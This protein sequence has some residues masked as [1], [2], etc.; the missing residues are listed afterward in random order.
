[1]VT[2]RNCYTAILAL[3]FLAGSLAAQPHSC[4]QQTV[5]GT[6]ALAFDGMVITSQAPV[7]VAGL[8]IVMIDPSGIVNAPGYMA[9]GSAPQWYPQGPGAMIVNT[10]CTGEVAWKD[11]QGQTIGIGELIV[12]DGGDEIDSIMIYSA[13]GFPVITGRWKRISRVP[14]IDHPGMCSPHSVF[15]TY[16][17]REK[18]VHVIPGAGPV[19]GEMLARIAI[20]HSG[21]VAMSGMVMIAANSTPMPITIANGK[22]VEGALAC[23]GMGTGDLEVGGTKIG[24]VEDWFVVLDGGNELWGISV[25]DPIGNPVALWTVKRASHQPADQE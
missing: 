21:T 3:L 25:A 14:D 9:V 20:D 16:V 12:R 7:P 8:S 15:G 11:G 4:T 17:A 19:P 10:D 1:M 23:T 2:K 18:G 6:Y 5:V 22:W 24:S 13:S